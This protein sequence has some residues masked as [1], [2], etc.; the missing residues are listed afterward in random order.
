MSAV[1]S[2]AGGY[3]IVARG[4]CPP[5]RSAT[6]EYLPR[7]LWTPTSCIYDLYPAEWGFEWATFDANDAAESLGRIDLDPA[8]L[9]KIQ[10]WID[11]RHE[12]GQIGF[13]GVFEKLDT[14]LEFVSEFVRTVDEIQLLGI[15][16]SPERVH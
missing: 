6:R 3:F 2:I 4:T 16:L 14:A 12:T 11:K 8:A 9:P 1:Q 7:W 10:R 13:P 15:G 5:I